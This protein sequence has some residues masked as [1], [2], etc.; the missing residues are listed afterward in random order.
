[1]ERFLTYSVQIITMIKVL[2]IRL[3]M[4]P[5]GKFR[6]KEL[7][8]DEF[9]E[10]LSDKEIYT[11]I[12]FYSTKIMLDQLGIKYKEVDD[13]DDPDYIIA[14]KYMQNWLD[15]PNLIK[16]LKYGEMFLYEVIK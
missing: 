9:V 5:D 1:M 15:R 6:L 16:A 3:S 7:P 12:R 14:Y 2:D 10:K 8:L 4:M 11:T 13:V